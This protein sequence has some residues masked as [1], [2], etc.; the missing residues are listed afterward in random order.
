MRSKKLLSSICAVAIITGVG[1]KVFATTQTQENSQIESSSTM[2]KID[3]TSLTDAQKSELKTIR[4]SIAEVRNK[5]VDKYLELGVISEDVANNMKEKL[6]TKDNKKPSE[7]TEKQREEMKAQMDA[8]KEKW[9]SLSEAQKEEIYKLKDNIIDV[10]GKV[11][12]KYVEW[13]LVDK[14]TS[15]NMKEK[16]AERKTK[17][18]EDGVMPGIGM[19]RNHGEKGCKNN[20]K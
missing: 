6:S 11:I 19:G 7:L 4:S 3:K 13:G 15:E 1:T 8:M 5:I 20:S 18:R 9:N 10:E 12:D 16:M 14:T 17:M 2:K